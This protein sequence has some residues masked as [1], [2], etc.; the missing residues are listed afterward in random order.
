MN[1]RAT[2]FSTEFTFKTS[3][4]SGSGGQN[5][6]KV[7]TKVDLY[8]QVDESVLLDE[9]QKKRINKKL[10]NKINSEGQL[11]LSEQSSRSQFKNK[12][13]VIEKFHE[14]LEES[15]KVQKPRKATKPSKT[16]VAKR[17]KE[18]KIQSEKKAGRKN[19]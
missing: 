11:H 13:L 3:R 17:L 7:S 12:K 4:S 10:K 2:D 18:K 5:V 19:M 8:F 9:D 15:L 14:L 6:N 1:L 16:A